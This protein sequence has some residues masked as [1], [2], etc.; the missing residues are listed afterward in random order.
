MMVVPYLGMFPIV[1]TIETYPYRAKV[2]QKSEQQVRAVDR[3][4]YLGN[5]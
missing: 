2:F 3:D 5:N 4:I 1:T